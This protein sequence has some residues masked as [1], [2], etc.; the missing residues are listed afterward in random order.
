MKSHERFLALILLLFASPLAFA[1]EIGSGTPEESSSTTTTS[2]AEPATAEE[3]AD[4]EC[5]WQ[6]L[7]D[8]FD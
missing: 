4:A 8:W 7:L 1:D 2:S 6:L 3:S 5:L